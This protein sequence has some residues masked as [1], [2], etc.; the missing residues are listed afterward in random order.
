[1]KD[2]VSAYKNYATEYGFLFSVLEFSFNFEAPVVELYTKSVL[3][4][5]FQDFKFPDESSLLV[6]AKNF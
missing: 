6:S 2:F 3:S 4:T 1:L 5:F